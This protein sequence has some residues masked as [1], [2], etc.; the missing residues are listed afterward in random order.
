MQV[1][2][3]N[4]RKFYEFDGKSQVIHV[5]NCL[6][7]TKGVIWKV[8][9]DLYEDVKNNTYKIYVEHQSYKVYNELYII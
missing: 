6:N 8:S 7:K 2:N 9:A 4:E 3:I 1:K 5:F